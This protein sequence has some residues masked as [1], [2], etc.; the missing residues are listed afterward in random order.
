MKYQLKKYNFN[1]LVKKYNLELLKEEITFND[2]NI[3]EVKTIG[4]AV[5]RTSLVLPW[6]GLCLIKAL[7]AQRILIKYKLKGTIFMGVK[8]DSD[9]NKLEAHAW[10]KYNDIFLTGKAGHKDFTVVSKFTWNINE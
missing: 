3:K 6:E 4:W 2:E 10:L 7:A 5:E 1:Y 9:K 8:K